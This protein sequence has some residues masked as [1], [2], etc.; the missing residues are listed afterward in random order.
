MKINP[1]GINAYQEMAN[2]TQASRKPVAVNHTEPTQK[3]GKINIPGRVDKAGSDISVRLEGQD[4]AEMLSPE[5]KQA[6]ELLFEKYGD[7]RGKSG[8]ASV[9]PSGLG[10]FVDVKL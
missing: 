9:N 6:L 1:I 7:K 2:R 5:E 10:T 8:S 3:P 4:Y